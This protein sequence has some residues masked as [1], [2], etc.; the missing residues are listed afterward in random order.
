MSASDPGLLTSKPGAGELD[1]SQTL[2]DKTDFI[3]AIQSN[4][5]TLEPIAVGHRAI[6]ISQIGLI[7]CQLGEKLKWNP[8]QELFDGNNA[9]NALLAA[10]LA[11]KQW[12]M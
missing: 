10:P 3:V 5:K 6:S 4:G 12:A 1:F 8:E 9:A 7:A 2:S 11:R